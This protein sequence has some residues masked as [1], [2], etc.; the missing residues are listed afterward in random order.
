VS[1]VIGSVIATQALVW[2]NNDLRPLWLL[3]AAF[4]AI[5][6][7]PLLAGRVERGTLGGDGTGPG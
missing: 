4:M 1:G 6:L 5:A 2:T 3:G 7:V